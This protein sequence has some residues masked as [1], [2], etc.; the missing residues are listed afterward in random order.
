[1]SDETPF[2]SIAA[3]E[4]WR[5]GERQIAAKEHV[6]TLQEIRDL[7]YRADGAPLPFTRAAREYI[8]TAIDRL[9]ESAPATDE[10]RDGGDS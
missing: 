3:N 2:V 4:R 10:N 6:Q 8:D 1:M 9:L 5:E 7:L